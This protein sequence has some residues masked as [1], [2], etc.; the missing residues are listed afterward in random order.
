MKISFNNGTGLL[1][2]GYGYANF[3]LMTNLT[4]LGYSVMT[5]KI[6]ADV[7]I[8]F[9][10]PHLYQFFDDKSIRVGYTPWESTLLP[11]DEG[12]WIEPMQN[13]H[14]VW[15]PNHFTKNVFE[16]NGVKDVKVFSH[17]VDDTFSP[18]ERSLKYKLRFL[19][20][21]HPALRKGLADTIDSF[22]DL[23]AGNN[24]VELVIKGYKNSDKTF[25]IPDKA[26][27][28]PNIKIILDNLNYTQLADLFGS[29]HV[30]LYPSWGEGFGLIPLQSM[31]TGMPSIFTS[32][33]ADYEYLASD[34]SIKSSLHKSPWQIL[35]PGEMFKPDLNDFK[36]KILMVY[37]NPEHYLR[38]FEI[39]SHE[40]HKDWN[41]LSTVEKFFNEFKGRW[42]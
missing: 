42:V 30:L 6:P 38:E 31:A 32:G 29:C 16:E 1:P 3:K 36:E 8:N 12:D 4:K 11:S 15:A 41:W 18:R 39:K 28:E 40:I 24:D 22:L 23:F 26:Y 21:G 19:H 17:G 13:C 37:K 25:K 7:E 34:L 20:V 35:H 14:E 9:I 33:W 27:K 5:N 10:Q 2:T